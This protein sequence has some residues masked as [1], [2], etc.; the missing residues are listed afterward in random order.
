MVE[1][2]GTLVNKEGMSKETHFELLSSGT[3]F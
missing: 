1:S 2:N 3:T